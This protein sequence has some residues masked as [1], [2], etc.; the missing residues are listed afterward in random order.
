MQQAES[1]NL[2]RNCTEAY[3]APSAVFDKRGD[4]IL[5]AEIDTDRKTLTEYGVTLAAAHIF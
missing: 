2:K 5:L 3:K 1:P 4:I